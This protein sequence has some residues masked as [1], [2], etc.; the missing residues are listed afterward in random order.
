MP[1]ADL[2]FT[3]TRHLPAQALLSDVEKAIHAFDSGAGACKGRA[4]PLETHHDHALLRLS[5]LPKPH[6]D[7][8]YARDLGARLADLIA[9]QAPEGMQIGVQISFDLTHYSTRQT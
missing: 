9:A 7:A 4:H 1:Q 6:R 2:Y 8:G 5:M 3:A